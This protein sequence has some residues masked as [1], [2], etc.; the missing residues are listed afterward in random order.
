MVEN[1]FFQYLYYSLEVDF[2]VN[3]PSLLYVAA[4]TL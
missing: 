3:P 4:H 2:C 1:I